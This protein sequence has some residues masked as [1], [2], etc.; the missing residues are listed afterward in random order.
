[1]GLNVHLRATDGEFL[2]YPTRYRHIVGSL[3]YL[4]VTRPEISHML[5][6]S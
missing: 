1:M 4:G 2:A 6:I 5:Y 3:V